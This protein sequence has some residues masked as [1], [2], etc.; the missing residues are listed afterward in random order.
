MEETMGRIRTVLPL[1]AVFALVG[2]AAT[3]PA[4]VPGWSLT[5]RMTIDSG[6]GRQPTIIT[7]KM[8]GA[9]RKVRQEMTGPGVP[10]MA[11]IM[12]MTDSTMTVVMEQM[13]MAMTMR[14]PSAVT[15]MALGSTHSNVKTVR[16]D[17]G[18]GEALNGFPTMRHR[19]TI[20]STV[21]QTLGTLTCSRPQSQ[22]IEAWIVNDPVLPRVMADF[23]AAMPQ[24]AS[25]AN[26]PRDLLRLA[27]VDPLKLGVAKM[28]SRDVHTGKDSALTMTV[29][30]MDYAI[31]DVE[32]SKLAA[33]SGVQV[34][35]MRGMDMSAMAGG[36]MGQMRDQMFW[37]VFDTTAAAGSGRATCARK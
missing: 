36:A 24:V 31:L 17:L 18:P 23:T 32:P 12:D 34:Q 33:P 14:I 13:G 3:P 28:V 20:T 26:D 8:L 9:G 7:M 16:A 10:P 19:I 5:M 27:G 22:E 25:P 15:A 2:A 1:V 4:R 11:S 21:S 6:G 30:F 35:D 29:E 37:T